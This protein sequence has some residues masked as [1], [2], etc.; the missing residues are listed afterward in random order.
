MCAFSGC[1]C[2]KSEGPWPPCPSASDTYMY[3][4]IYIASILLC[5]H[6]HTYYTFTVFAVSA[7]VTAHHRPA[8]KP[9]NP[10]LGETYE[11]I[12][13][14]KGFRF[15]AEQVRVCANACRLVGI[16]VIWWLCSDGRLWAWNTYTWM[17]PS[18]LKSLSRSATIL[19]L[20]PAIVSLPTSPSGKVCTCTY[21]PALNYCVV[22]SMEQNV[23]GGY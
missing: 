21:V 17:S 15:V 1:G 20:L 10:I 19:L 13:E 12:R 16:C 2:Q 14:D 18:F 8:R 3:M 4:Y 9:F 5:T 7:Y 6:V 11:W 23:C 22:F